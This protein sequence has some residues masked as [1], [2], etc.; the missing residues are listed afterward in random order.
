M[1]YNKEEQEIDLIDLLFELLAHWRG[2]L[3][4]M[5]VVALMAAAYS[6]ISSAQ[7]ANRATKQLQQIEQLQQDNSSDE[8]ISEQITETEKLDAQK[9]LIYESLYQA[10]KAYYENSFLMKCDSNAMYTVTLTYT[11]NASD[12]VTACDIQQLYGRTISNSELNGKLSEASG[13]HYEAVNELISVKADNPERGSII[14]SV[15]LWAPD[16]EM[17]DALTRVTRQ[18]IE[19]RQKQLCI[20]G[21]EHTL[22]EVCDS[23]GPMVWRELLDSQES[24]QN[25]LIA[26]EAKIAT[27]RDSL[28]SKNEVWNYYITQGG[29][30]DPIPEV[31]VSIKITLLGAIIGLFLYAALIC[32][33][34][35]FTNTLKCSDSV[36]QQY[37]LSNL[38]TVRISKQVKK[39]PLHK[40]DE[41]LFSLRDRNKR[42]LTDAEAV[43]LAGIQAAM[44]AKKAGVDR[45][46]V[47]GACLKE[48]TLRIC[49]ALKARLMQDNFQVI[50]LPDVLYNAESAEKLSSVD[51]AV[52]VE[53]VASTRYEELNSEMEILARLGI[54][55]LGCVTLE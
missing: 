25:D 50:I 36:Y 29:V 13:V 42:K 1:N 19:D 9:L 34:Y 32:A 23:Q 2:L 24:M 26:Y 5:L 10:K 31:R 48:D 44:V 21:C 22:T 51:A 33:K 4:S 8:S 16:Q 55:V 20:G 38:G 11:V 46:C 52:L 40:V 49:E 14:F 12:R 47:L 45:I 7:E 37:Q 15:T 28:S 39:L 6:Y 3:I 43:Q 18:Y 17:A 30:S 53:T 35:I 41:I 54:P 27:L